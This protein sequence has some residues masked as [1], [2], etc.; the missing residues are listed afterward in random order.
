MINNPSLHTHRWEEFSFPWEGMIDWVDEEVWLKLKSQGRWNA[1]ISLLFDC[2]YSALGYLPFSATNVS[3]RER[4]ERRGNLL[5][6]AAKAAHALT[7]SEA[8]T[9]KVI[10]NRLA[11]RYSPKFSSEVI[12]RASTANE[13]RT[14]RVPLTKHTDE[15]EPLRIRHL[16]LLLVN[17]WNGPRVI[18]W[19]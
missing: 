7:R 13:G 4:E 1:A 6:L 5:L 18:L 9:F 15:N 12:Y 14:P 10:Q 3:G 11:A 2:L 16:Y 19:F 8:V 17:S